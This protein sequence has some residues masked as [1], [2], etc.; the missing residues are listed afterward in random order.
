MFTLL[1]LI[2]VEKEKDDTGKFKIRR[3]LLEKEE[4]K[5]WSRPGHEIER[6]IRAT[7][8]AKEIRKAVKRG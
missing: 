2:P 4:N 8:K 3:S 5:K 1:G 7:E 6:N